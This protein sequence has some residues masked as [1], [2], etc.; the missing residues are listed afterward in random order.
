[1]RGMRDHKPNPLACSQTLTAMRRSV[2]KLTFVV[3]NTAAV[4]AALYIAFASDLE[5]PYWAMFT[6]FIVAK[7]ITGAVRSKAV[8][9][10]LGTVIGASIALLLVPPMVQAPVL[11]CLAIGLWVGLCVY[12]SLQDRRPRSYA[13]L[14]A[15]YT[16][17]IIGFSV[18]ST[19]EG[20]FDTCVSRVEEISVGL[21]CA[22]VAHSV[23]FPQNVLQELSERVDGLLRRS[24]RWISEALVVRPTTYLEAQERLAELVGDLH[25]LYEHVAFETSDVPRNLP[26]AQALQDR[27]IALLPCVSSI[28]NTV[29]ALNALGP[30]T[31]SALEAIEASARWARAFPDTHVGQDDHLDTD[32]RAAL[33]RFRAESGPSSEWASLL[34]RTLA[35][36]LQKLKAELEVAAQLADALRN[37]EERPASPLQDGPTS[38]HRLHRDRGLALLSA[39]AATAAALIACALWIE[40]SWPEGTVAAQFAAIGCSLFATLDRPSKILLAAVAGILLALPVAALYEFAIFPR[41]DGF[42][43]LALVLTPMMLLFSWMQT[44][45]RLEGI[46]LVLS[47]AFAGGLA[48]QSSYRADFAAFLNSNSAEIVGLLIAA[49][50]NLL[51]RTIDPVWNALRI[52]K[53]GWRAVISLAQRP[54]SDLSAWTLQMFDRVGLVAQRLLSAKRRDLFGARVD[55]IRDLRV[56]VNLSTLQRTSS[57]V[58]PIARTSIDAVLDAVSARYRSL[59]E[60]GPLV[61]PG[62]S[63]V[64]DEGIAA[65]GA[66]PPVQAVEEGLSALVGLRLDLWPLTSR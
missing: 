20:V 59:L 34:Q 35:T 38:R 27:L 28:E 43:S 41:I 24:G 16:A 5:R 14:L 10:F 32:A 61:R 25:I 54:R 45:E 9:R 64:I 50:T 53:A 63:E 6:V 33:A 8:F 58:P 15:G 46:A 47:I 22:A 29:T 18:V 3:A 21:I 48:L 36:Q 65:F 57:A 56:G 30:L 12:L 2:Q 37:P 13:F 40:G 52:S 7:P 55:G 1:M 4:I 17:A 51:F 49:A 62:S 42:A 26:V 11:L 44:F 23:F 39:F 31:P 66:Q 60:G 19:P